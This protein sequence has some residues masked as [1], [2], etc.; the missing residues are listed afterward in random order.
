[1]RDFFEFSLFIFRNLISSWFDLDIGGYS[2]GSFL[3]ACL[4]LSIFVSAL[5]LK[6]RSSDVSSATK[7]PKFHR[8]NDPK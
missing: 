3:T 1:M 7:P 5:V 8:S 2:Y 6:F 4:V